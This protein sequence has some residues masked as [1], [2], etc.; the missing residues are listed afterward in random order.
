MVGLDGPE[1]VGSEGYLVGSRDVVQ[2]QDPG[3]GQSGKWAGGDEV[4][5]S[6]SCVDR[7]MLLVEEDDASDDRNKTTNQCE[8]RAML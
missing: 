5:S 8:T 2:K 6:V 3:S 7:D 4:Q 1:T